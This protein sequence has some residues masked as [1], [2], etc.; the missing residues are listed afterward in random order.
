MEAI[1]PGETNKYLSQRRSQ[2]DIHTILGTPRDLSRPTRTSGVCT[3]H[4]CLYTRCMYTGKKGCPLIAT[5]RKTLVLPLFDLD[6]HRITFAL[7]SSSPLHFLL[8]S[9]VGSVEYPDRRRTRRR[10][11]S[12]RA[13]KEK[14]ACLLVHISSKERLFES[15][16]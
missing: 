3:Q 15:F 16:L 1:L 5:S 14:R 7:R 10:I 11:L 8:L 6:P 9:L 13:G 2:E 12:N 4:A